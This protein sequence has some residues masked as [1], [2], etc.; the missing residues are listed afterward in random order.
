VRSTPPGSTPVYRPHAGVHVKAA[1]TAV[2]GTATEGAAHGVLGLDGVA[3]GGRVVELPSG[4]RPPQKEL[5]SSDAEGGTMRSFCSVRLDEITRS[6]LDNRCKRRRQWCTR[7]KQY[8]ISGDVFDK[9]R[10]P[11]LKV[12]VDEQ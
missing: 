2:E 9:H 10:I 12:A 5:A 4:D 7:P 6:A 1:A 11:A 3:S 8:A